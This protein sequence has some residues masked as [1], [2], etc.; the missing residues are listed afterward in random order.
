MIEPLKQLVNRFEVELN[1]ED[2]NRDF[3]RSLRELV[4][5]LFA[6]VFGV[7]LSELGDF[8]SLS[9]WRCPDFWVLVTAYIAVVGSWWGYHWAT[10]SGPKETNVLNY[11]VD[12]LLL[13]VY[14]LLINRRE[15]VPLVLFW[16]LLMFFLYFLWELLRSCR[17]FSPEV[18][19]ALR[20][21]II[22]LVV[23]SVLW[24]GSQFLGTLGVFRLLRNWWVIW[25]TVLGIL[26][27]YRWRVHLIYKP[28]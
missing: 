5:I 4:T 16:Y 27:T 9:F 12:C 1:D 3:Y 28:Q 26:I 25:P 7:G 15:L 17:D 20:L 13:V 19:K 24:I 14:W 21:N 8:Q 11:L 10:I 2:K 23:M 6:V 18:K 22:V